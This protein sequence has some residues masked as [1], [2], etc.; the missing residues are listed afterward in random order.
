MPIGPTNMPA[1]V[2]DMMNYILKDLI[3][4]GIQVYID[5]IQIYVTNI[6]QH[7]TLVEEV[8]ERLGKN[9]L[10]VHLQNVFALKK[11]CNF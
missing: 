3:D 2:E 1:S 4:K 7:N 5:D 8:L 11:G 10:S 9:D 6:E